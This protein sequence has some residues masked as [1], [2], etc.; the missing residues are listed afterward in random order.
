MRFLSV[1]E[2]N[3][4][5]SCKVQLQN[6]D[7]LR[8]EASQEL[9]GQTSGGVGHR[10]EIFGAGSWPNFAFTYLTAARMRGLED[11]SSLINERGQCWIHASGATCA[12]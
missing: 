8:C 3:G 9:I 10:S 7:E 4:F 1:R 2:S 6:K 12:R 5:T 11:N